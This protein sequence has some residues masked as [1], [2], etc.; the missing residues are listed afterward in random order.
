MLVWL[1][2]T[3]STRRKFYPQQN[4][5]NLSSHWANLH[6]PLYSGDSL[7]N[8]W[9]DAIFSSSHLPRCF[10]S[11]AAVLLFSRKNQAHLKQNK[12]QN[13]TQTKQIKE[14][15]LKHFITHKMLW[16]GFMFKMVILFLAIGLMLFFC[17]FFRPLKKLEWKY[18]T[19][20]TIPGKSLSTWIQVYAENS[21]YLAC[22]FVFSLH[23]RDYVGLR[24]VHMEA[25]RDTDNVLKTKGDL[26]YMCAHIHKYLF[27]Q[28]VL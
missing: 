25:A 21:K 16:D 22:G 27:L 7:L 17:W 8:P 28:L 5:R 15:V 23:Q 13:T 9:S 20:F 10:C 14:N 26:A 4:Q 2:L 6:H 12:S 1:Y 19:G 11:T 3:T 18:F 24:S